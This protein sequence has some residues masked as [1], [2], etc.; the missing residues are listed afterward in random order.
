MPIFSISLSTDLE[1]GSQSDFAA[2][3][4]REVM[5][6]MDVKELKDAETP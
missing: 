1:V 5:G 3:M 6:L 2:P 4:L